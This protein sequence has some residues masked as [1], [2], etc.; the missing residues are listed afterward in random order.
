MQIYNMYID[1]CIIFFFSFSLSFC[2]PF[3]FFY[4]LFFLFLQET[5]DAAFAVGEGPCCLI[6]EVMLPP[7]P[8]FQAP[9]QLYWILEEA[10]KKQNVG[11]FDVS[12]HTCHSLLF[13]SHSHLSTTNVIGSI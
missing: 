12:Q 4:L 3:F 5:P 2:L 10:R 11:R 6:R 1:R 8:H 7:L 13:P 9:P